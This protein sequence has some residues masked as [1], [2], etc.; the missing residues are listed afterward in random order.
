MKYSLFI[1]GKKENNK[2]DIVLDIEGNLKSNAIRFS[3]MHGLRS[4]S[5]RDL[6]PRV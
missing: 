1:V 4:A 3:S 2:R 5:L 6:V